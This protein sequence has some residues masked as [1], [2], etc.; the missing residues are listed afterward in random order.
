VSMMS[1]GDPP[2]PPDSV[3]ART[4]RGAGWVMAWRMV[5]RA[6]GFASTL[7]LVRLLS[8]EDFGL[9]ALATAFAIALDVC[10]EIGV[11]DQII[12]TPQPSAALYHTAFTLAL[13]R[14]IVTGALVMALAA[15][16]A[17]FFGNPRLGPVLV[18]LGLLAMA[19]GLT[20]IGVVD[21]R[22]DMDFAREFRFLLWPRLAGIGVTISVALIAP[23]EWALVAGMATNRLGQV[24]LSYT[25]HPLRPRLMLQEWRALAG[26]SFWSWGIGMVAVARDRSESF[27]IGRVQG[28]ADVGIFAAGA[29]I[30]WLPT[31]EMVAP[32]ARACFPGFAAS[33]REGGDMAEAWRR[34]TS[35]S[36]LISL[37]TGMG[38][39][40]VAADLVYLA[41]GP[42]W[43]A[44][45]PVVVIIG[46][47][48][49]LSPLGSVSQAMLGAR[50]MLRTILALHVL[51]TLVRV[52]LLVVLTPRLGLLGAALAVALAA[53]LDSATMVGMAQ[54][55]LG[56]RP[57]TLLADIARPLLAVS[58]MAALLWSLGLGWTGGPDGVG[59]ALQRLLLAV[60][61]G[62]AC[63][64]A[65]GAALWWLAG[66]PA[67][68]AEADLLA[69][70]RQVLA[71]GR[72]ASG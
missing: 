38:L 65:V 8:P 15:P 18:A 32:V 52:A 29:E 2:G 16:A 37:P 70:L 7:V 63:H 41:Y 72:A 34:I 55:R 23:G 68:S 44:A 57:G 1:S 3:L 19:D 27:V 25:M 31:T 12:R 26:V 24:V 17:A 56:L 67:A 60:P 10:L 11:E 59:E 64:V 22:R 66:R 6:L 13:I 14:A 30:A 58:A 9:V 48:A 50:T 5:T 43:M 4:A 45:A 71:R 42:A 35:L 33:S 54:H 20:N 39:S 28:P 40:L 46:L 47:A 21:F 49:A 51:T 62:A 53:L 69:T 36:A 61:L